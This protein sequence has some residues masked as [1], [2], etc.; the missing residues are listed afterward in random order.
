MKQIVCMKWG[1]KYGPEYVN[2]LYGM[3][4]RN[5]EG[6]IRFVCLT[7]HAEG[8]RKEVECYPCPEIAIPEPFCNYPWRK[9]SLWADQLDHMDDTWLFL[10]LDIVV[11]N[12]LD[13]L[14]TYKTDASFIVM[15]NWTQPNSGIGNTSVYRFKVGSHPYLLEKLLKD[16]ENIRN[17]YRNSQTYISKTIKEIEYW[18]DEWCVLF[19]VQCVPPMPF[20]WWQKPKL[21][22]NAKVV[23]F[24][25]DPN[26]DD[27]LIGEWPTHKWYKKSYKY[28]KPSLWINDYW[29][30]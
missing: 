7:D 21:P 2:K 13:E 5:L 22:N 9:V 28:I 30:E 17:T 27:A 29:Y 3:V 8:I 6:E 11:T 24:P 4:R 1:N 18:P 16:P 10:D 14:F 19:K 25:G 20:R 15:H 23:A 12:K 26:P